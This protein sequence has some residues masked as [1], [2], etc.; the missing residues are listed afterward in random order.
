MRYLA[1]AS[2][3]ERH[4]EMSRPTFPEFHFWKE[5]S[6]KD[7]DVISDP[8]EVTLF[9]VINGLNRKQMEEL[10]SCL[11][12]LNSDHYRSIEIPW[13]LRAK[14]FIA[15][16]NHIS[17]EEVSDADQFLPEWEFNG[18]PL[19]YRLYY[20]ARY[21]NLT[22]VK[23]TAPDELLYLVGDFF[24]DCRHALYLTGLI[25]QDSMAA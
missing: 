23:D 22:G 16:R 7:R 21:P 11:M 17:L 8:R 2:D 24:R 14:R 4:E 10:D 6:K 5:L 3:L 15:E 13:M 12:P 18:T 25:N 9:N 1:L 20:V 19:R